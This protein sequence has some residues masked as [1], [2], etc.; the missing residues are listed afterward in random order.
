MNSIKLADLLTDPAH[1]VAADTPVTQAL[2]RM[3]RLRIGALGV[4]DE[5]GHPVGVFT[6]HDAVLAACHREQG[7]DKAVREVMTPPALTAPADSEAL[8]AF[9]RMVKSGIRHPVFRQRARSRDVASLM[10]RDLTTLPTDA[11]NED[12]VRLMAE[13]RL[14]CVMVAAAG[15]ASLARPLGDIMRYPAASMTLDASLAEAIQG[16][17][18]GRSAAGERCRGS[19]RWP[20]QRAG[21]CHRLGLPC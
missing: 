16:P 18:A 3:R 5:Q 14:D 17:I 20:G 7:Q 11:R 15:E 4:T 2:E 12:A 10:R 9:Q 8:A 13:Q 21:H 1:S 19:V 6:E